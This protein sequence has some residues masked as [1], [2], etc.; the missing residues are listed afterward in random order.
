MRF[1]DDIVLDPELRSVGLEKR[2]DFGPGSDILGVVDLRNRV[3]LAF[4]GE[5]EKIAAEQDRAGLGES[6]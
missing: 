4:T 3:I 1:S 2:F 6:Y 5:V